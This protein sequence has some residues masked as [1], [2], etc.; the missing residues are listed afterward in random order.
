MRPRGVFKGRPH[1]GRNAAIKRFDAHPS[2]QPQDLFATIDGKTPVVL[3]LLGTPWI[4]RAS[5]LPSG[6]GAGKRAEVPVA[7]VWDADAARPATFDYKGRRHA[8]DTIVAQWSIE[9]C[10][11]DRS[12]AV[13]RRCFR[14]LARGGVWDLAYDRLLK[15]WLLVGVVD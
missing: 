14:V 13:S 3:E 15:E 12:S 6:D 11:W 5:D 4:R 9:R 10:W 2:G 7:V 8:I 1:V